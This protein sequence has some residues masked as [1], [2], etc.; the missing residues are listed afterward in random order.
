MKTI[1]LSDEVVVNLKRFIDCTI[2]VGERADYYELLKHALEN[3]KP[4]EQK[5]SEAEIK[6]ELLGLNARLTIGDVNRFIKGL[7]TPKPEMREMNVKEKEP[8]I[9]KL[10]FEYTDTAIREKVKIKFKGECFE[11]GL[12]GF[13]QDDSGCTHYRVSDSTDWLPIPQIEVK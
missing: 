1:E 9:L 13:L 6:A 10:V 2:F 12:Y 11:C 3:A 8:W 7:K 5:W 4:V